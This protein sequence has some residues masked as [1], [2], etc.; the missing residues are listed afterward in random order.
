MG[1]HKLDPRASA[2]G[3][4]LWHYLKNNNLGPS[5]FARMVGYRQSVISDI[6]HGRTARPSARLLK[7]MIDNTS[8]TAEYLLGEGEVSQTNVPRS[9]A[10]FCPYCG[11]SIEETGWKFCPDCGKKIPGNSTNPE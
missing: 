10:K 2:C 11:R 3:A 6:L 7:A 1:L 4:R 9:A 8:L 5:E